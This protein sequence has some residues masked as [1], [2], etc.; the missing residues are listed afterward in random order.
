MAVLLV[1]GLALFLGT[2]IVSEVVGLRQPP[3]PTSCTDSDNGTNKEAFGSCS[4]GLRITYYDTCV[5]T[6]VGGELQIQEYF[7]ENNACTSQIFDC[8]E[9]FVCSGGKCIMTS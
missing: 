1:L 7:C 5:L 4:N 6:S 8:D 2:R 9:G 3:V